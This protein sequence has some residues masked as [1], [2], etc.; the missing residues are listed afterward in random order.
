V[1]RFEGLDLMANL[2][3]PGW[4][5]TTGARALWCGWR[6]TDTSETWEPNFQGIPCCIEGAERRAQTI[7]FRVPFPPARFLPAPPEGF[8]GWSQWNDADGRTQQQVIDFLRN[9][10]AIERVKEARAA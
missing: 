7:L 8:E 6:G 1:K 10:A 3:E 2:V 4:S 9:L 5:G